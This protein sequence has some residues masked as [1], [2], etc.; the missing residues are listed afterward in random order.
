[1]KEI[2]MANAAMSKGDMRGACKNYM[3]AQK[4]GFE[5]RLKVFMA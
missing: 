1:M 5:E 2:G 4:N 3:R